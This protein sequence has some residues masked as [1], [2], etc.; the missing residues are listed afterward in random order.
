MEICHSSTLE[1]EYLEQQAKHAQTSTRT[2]YIV[3]NVETISGV[4]SECI[5]Q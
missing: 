1:L 5:D 4:T 2:K 3:D